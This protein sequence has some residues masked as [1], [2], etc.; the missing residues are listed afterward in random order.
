MGAKVSHGKYCAAAT[1]LM[2]NGDVVRLAASKGSAARRIPSPVLE[3]NEPKNSDRNPGPS[4][5]LVPNRLLQAQ[6][7]CERFHKLLEGPTAPQG[8]WGASGR[9]LSDPDVMCP[10][11]AGVCDTRRRQPPGVEAQG[12]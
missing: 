10:R 3:T 11:C 2:S 1:V 7:P 8:C 12:G 4:E 5:P 9:S 6:L